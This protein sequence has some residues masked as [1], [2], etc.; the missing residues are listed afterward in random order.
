MIQAE[1]S[2]SLDLTGWYRHVS[3]FSYVIADDRTHRVEEHVPQKS[4]TYKTP[5]LIG[6]KQ[7]YKKG[8]TPPPQLPCLSAF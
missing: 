8:L 5:H 7:D 2:A 6:N 4:Q 3:T 1:S